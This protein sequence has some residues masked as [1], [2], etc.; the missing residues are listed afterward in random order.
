MAA[1]YVSNIT[2]NSG[3]DFNQTFTLESADSSSPLNLTGYSVSSQMRKHAGSTTKTDFTAEALTPLTDGRIMISLTNT[4][5]AALKAGRYVYDIVIEK[6]STKTRV[7]GG[8][9]LVK[10]GVTR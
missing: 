4:Q 3:E 6:G 10:Q 8:M 7:L 9:V 2:V 5:T 1:T